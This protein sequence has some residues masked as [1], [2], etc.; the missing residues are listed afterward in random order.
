MTRL[1]NNANILA[2]GARTTGSGL[3]LKGSATHL[4]QVL[5]IL[6][7]NAV[8]YSAPGGQIDLVLERS[9]SHSLLSIANPGE[10]ISREDLKNIFKRF[11]RADK[12]RIRDGS[13]GLGLSIA[14]R[15][16]EEHGGRIWA[17]S[18]GGVNTFFVQL[19]E[20]G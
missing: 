14:Q 20:N 5:G 8:K 7:D 9:G 17:E 6:L 1:H 16:V 10:P 2:L 13:Y 18:G 4:R 12:S 3:A 15:I 19:P 11:Y